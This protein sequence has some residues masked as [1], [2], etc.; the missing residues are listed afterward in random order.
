MRSRSILCLLV[1]LAVVSTVRA[2][3][4]V[5]S[6]PIVGEKVGPLTVFAVT[7]KH[8]N[9]QL[10]YV[11]DRK[12]KPTVYVFIQ[13]DRW[14]RPMARFL[15]G[16]DGKVKG[17]SEDAYVV[18]VWLTDDHDKTRNYLPRADRALKLNDTALTYYPKE[19]AGP[20]AWGINADAGLTAV[21][22]NAGQAT[23]TFG[24]VSI[25][26]TV[27]PDVVNALKEALKKK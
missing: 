6:G 16:L 21:V 1:M 4:D 13:A 3:S 24:Y 14:S 26:E 15:R 5:V 18:A 25:N 11:A 2:D 27:V 23:A 10:D 19:K 22:V 20:G 12:D 8:E 7:G 9:K 17:T